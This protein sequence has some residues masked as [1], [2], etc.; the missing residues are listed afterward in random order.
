MKRTAHATRAIRVAGSAISVCGS[1]A[2]LT[3][4]SVEASD[5]ASW[6]STLG[7]IGI[8]SR[9]R[10]SH[11]TKKAPTGVRAGGAL[12]TWRQDEWKRDN[13]IVAHPLGDDAENDQSRHLSVTA[14]RRFVNHCG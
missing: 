7:W 5:I 9:P 12:I 11:R 14:R 1:K 2:H 13:R 3:S 10:M 4:R 8:E 6:I